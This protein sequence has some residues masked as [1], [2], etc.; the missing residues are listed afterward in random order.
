MVTLY[1]APSYGE[2]NAVVTITIKEPNQNDMQIVITAFQE[3]VGQLNRPTVLN[4][5]CRT[6][7]TFGRN[8]PPE[9]YH[10]FVIQARGISCQH[11]HHELRRRMPPAL[12][13]RVST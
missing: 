3:Y 11:L 1:R 7:T 12:K 6:N 10:I 13:G 8:A 5:N 2:D 9:P 4:D